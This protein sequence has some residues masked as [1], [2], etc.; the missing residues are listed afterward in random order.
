VTSSI[1]SRLIVSASV[2]LFCFLGLAGAALDTAYQKGAKNALY[3]R[4]QIH[5]Y[6]ILANAELSNNGKLILPSKP[7]EPR[8][9]QVDSGLYA[10]VFD[11]NGQ[12]VW[13]SHSSAGQVDVVLNDLTPGEKFFKQQKKA[14]ELA[15]ELHYKV[16]L[17]NANGQSKPFQLVIRESTRGLDSQVAGFRTVLWQWL[18]GIAFI[19][20]IV[21]FLIL[22]QSLE[23][24]RKIVQDLNEIRLAERDHLDNQYGEE[25]KDIADTLNKLIDNERMHLRR[26]RNTLADLAHSLKTPLSVLMGLY[27]QGDLSRKDMGVFKSHTLQMRQLVDYQL[28]KAAVK[29]HQTM[30][31]QVELEP[32]VQQIIGSL[33]KVYKHKHLKVDVKFDEHIKYSIE[34]GDLFEL[35]GNL[36]D[37]AFNWAKTELSVSAKVVKESIDSPSGVQIIIEDDGP[38]IAADDLASA[39]QR[40]IKVDESMAGNGIGLAIVN[41][42]V[43]SYRGTFR[44][45]QGGLGGQRWLIF[46]PT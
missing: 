36:L 35:L 38:G 4:L 5:L 39:L 44:S 32:I 1:Q 19:L 12:L 41:E 40:G 6:S 46:L 22:R 37:N 16:I 3:E 29:G 8:F 11:D 43:D 25:L 14:G 15:V 10:Y 2:V 31:K 9:S 30:A 17:E 28:H 34:K 23:P 42:V 20:L 18:G 24:L 45:E 21:Q 26:Y 7:A 13:R 27:G 33:H